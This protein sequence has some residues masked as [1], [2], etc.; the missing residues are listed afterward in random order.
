M[1][2]GQTPMTSMERKR[3]TLDTAAFVD[4]A[5]AKAV[6]GVAAADLREVTERI[7]S[8][9]YK[10]LGKAPRLLDGD[11]MGQL[12]GEVLPRRFGKKD[13]LAGCVASVLGAYLDFLIGVEM[14]V[15][16]FE[17]RTALDAHIAGFET[18]VALG[19]AHADGVVVTDKPEPFKHRAHKT[20]RNDPCPC[21]SGKK[22]KK[23]CGKP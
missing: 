10:D 9:C 12:L 11:D 15:H 4:S 19:T 3:V 8:A 7:L 17:L 22:F 2:A 23:C 21:G 6:A 20:G 5:Q 13:R 18:A 1:E 16:E 14:V